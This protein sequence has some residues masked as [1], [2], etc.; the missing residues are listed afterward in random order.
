MGHKHQSEIHRGRDGHF[1]GIL[2][3]IGVAILWGFWPALILFILFGGWLF[4]R[5]RGFC[6]WMMHKIQHDEKPKR[7]AKNDDLGYSDDVEYV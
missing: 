6:G 5:E 3:F 4:G 7:K 1:W 2:I